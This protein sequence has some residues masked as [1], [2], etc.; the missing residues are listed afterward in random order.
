M[1]ERGGDGGGPSLERPQPPVAEDR[2]TII[3]VAIGLLLLVLFVIFVVQN[4]DPVRVSFVF[5]NARIRL[6]WVFLGCAVL[7]GIIAWLVGRP[8]RRA[9]RRLIEE[10]ER[11]R[12][13]RE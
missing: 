12:R 9:M 11:Q 3:K 13:G 5:F 7:G 1:A 4:S 6:V 10:L 8:R 2:G